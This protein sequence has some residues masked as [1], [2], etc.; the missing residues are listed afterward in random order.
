MTSITKDVMRTFLIQK[1]LPAI[2]EKWPREEIGHP[3]FIQQDNARTH[4]HCE[5][6]EF[7]L[8]VTQDGFEHSI[9][10]LTSKLTRFKYFRSW[11]FQFNTSL[12]T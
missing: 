6:E 9:N 11:F 5:D 3:I 7:C 10:V 1:V 12:T 2:K 4:L 8:A